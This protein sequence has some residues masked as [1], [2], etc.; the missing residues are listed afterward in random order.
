MS[1]YEFKEY[2]AFVTQK[3]R[4]LPKNGHGE[5]QKIAKILGMHTTSI[6][7]VFKGDKELSLEQAAK[8]CAYFTLSELESDYFINLVELARAG[9]RE[10]KFIIEKRLD[11]IR[12]QAEDLSN[13]VP[14]D[15]ILSEADKSK[16]YANWYYSAIRLLCDIPNL[17]N[18][19][20]IAKHLQIPLQ[21]ISEAMQFLL[22][23]GLCIEENGVLKMGLK[24][25]YLD[26]RSPLIA[27]H[28]ANW[29]LQAI[30]RY[31]SMDQ[32]TDLAF[33][34]P[35]TLSEEDAKKIREILLAK[36]EE[37]MKVN[38]DSPSEQLRVLNIDW[39]KI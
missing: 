31:D 17:N 6:S 16:F 27:R 26:S 35:M 12:L 22:E 1:I 10:L 8:L 23:I 15:K 38:A 2:K 21:T 29:R 34:C 32:Q 36:I 28:H 33:T 9:T 7:Q 13:R 37:I 14:K 25:T 30:E 39:L 24:R 20:S 18:V 11:K 3:V 5:F 4:S 19:N